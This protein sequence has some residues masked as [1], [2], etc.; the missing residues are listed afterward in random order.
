MFTPENFIDTVQNGK[1]QFVK[2]AITHEGTA[3]VLNDFVDAQTAYTKDAVKAF[4]KVGTSLY[5]EAVTAGQ[6]FVNQD[7]SKYITIW[8][9]P[10]TK[11]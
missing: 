1:K 2:T 5:S 10:F 3:K 4:T 8:T 11:K 6:K 7:F 9:A